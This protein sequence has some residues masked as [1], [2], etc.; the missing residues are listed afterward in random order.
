MNDEEKYERELQLIFWISDKCYNEEVLPIISC[1]CV[2]RIPPQAHT[3]HHKIVDN[4]R[5]EIGN[6]LD[7]QPKLLA[8][9][10]FGV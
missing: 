5:G 2:I 4:I 10:Y 6:E 8:N 3:H 7:K 9:I 1:N